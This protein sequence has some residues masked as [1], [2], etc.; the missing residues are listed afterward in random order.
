MLQRLNE[1]Y[2]LPAVYITGNGYADFGESYDMDRTVYHYDHIA[3]LLETM[4]KGIDVRGYIAWSLMDSFE[5]Y[6]G[7]RYIGN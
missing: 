3:V 1:D 5:W 2:I 4:K 7:Y 6:D